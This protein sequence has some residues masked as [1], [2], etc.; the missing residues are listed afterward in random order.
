MMRDPQARFRRGLRAAEI[1]AAIKL[2]G[3]KV[4]DF[5]AGAFGETKREI[6]FADPGRSGDDDDHYRRVRVMCVRSSS[7]ART[8]RRCSRQ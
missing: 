4:D 6:R 8:L 3:I 7:R 5:A 2:D 1:K